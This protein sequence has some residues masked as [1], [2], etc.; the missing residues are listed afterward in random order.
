[1]CPTGKPTGIPHF[2]NDAPSLIYAILYGDLLMLLR[3][4]C[5]PYELNKGESQLWPTMDEKAYD[6]MASHRIRYKGCEK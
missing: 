1:M 3:N 5:R 4:Q 6:D 2:A